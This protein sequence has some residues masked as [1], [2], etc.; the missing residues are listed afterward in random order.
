MKLLISPLFDG[1]RPVN[2][3]ILALYGCILEINQGFFAQI[4]DLLVVDFNKMVEI[5]LNSC[6]VELYFRW[7]R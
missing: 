6:S 7:K 5:Q 4:P 3:A 2:A 1:L